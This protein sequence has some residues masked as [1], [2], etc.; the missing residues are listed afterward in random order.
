MLR[1]IREYVDFQAEE[2][3]DAVYLIA[4]EPKLR[5]TFGGLQKASRKLTHYLVERGI[6][7]GE[8]VALL[9]HNGYQTCRLFIGAMYG[10]VLRDP[11]QFAG[12]SITARICTEP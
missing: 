3:P 11:A 7:P 9:M 8:K 1:T 6:R 5:M 2:R 12:T 10:G 4:P